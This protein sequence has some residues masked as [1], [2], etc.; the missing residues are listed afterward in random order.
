MELGTITDIKKI[1]NGSKN[2]QYSQFTNNEYSDE[3]GDETGSHDTG[4]VDNKLSDLIDRLNDIRNEI[5]DI[6]SHFNVDDDEFD[7][8]DEFDG[9]SEPDFDID[10]E[11]DDGSE[12]YSQFDDESTEFEDESF[13]D[14][15]DN[16]E[17]DD[18]FGNE[19]ENDFGQPEDETDI[20]ADPSEKDANFQGNIRTV[21]GANLVYKR[22]HEDGNFEE[23][24]IY[25]V[26]DDIAKESKLRRAILAGTDIPSNSTESDDGNQQSSTDTVGNVQFL[27]ITGLPN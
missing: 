16:S 1:D 26:G 11:L 7:V 27:H 15:N 6:L 21:A 12:F 22:R 25:N 19:F 8:Y 4:S 9:Y 18:E 24:W 2:G 5:D 13:S 17:F 10:S 23:L 14:I 20:Q 3:F